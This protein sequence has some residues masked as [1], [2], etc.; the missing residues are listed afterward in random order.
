VLLYAVR[1]FQTYH[2]YDFLD[3]V[4]GADQL[5]KQCLPFS[6]LYCGFF[7]T[8]LFFDANRKTSVDLRKGFE[9][10]VEEKETVVSIDDVWGG[11]ERAIIQ[12]SEPPS[13]TLNSMG[14]A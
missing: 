3:G 11:M 5:S 10:P 4:P 13:L 14:Q 12:G 6:C 7:P 2:R 8:V 1:C 9:V